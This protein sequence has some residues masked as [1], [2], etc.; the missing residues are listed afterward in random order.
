MVIPQPGVLEK[1]PPKEVAELAEYEKS[2]KGDKYHCP[3]C[4]RY[5]WNESL[6]KKSKKLWKR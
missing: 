5:A 1:D 3:V 2:F 4:G 6:R